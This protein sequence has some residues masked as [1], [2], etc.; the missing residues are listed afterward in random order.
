MLQMAYVQLDGHERKRACREKD[1]HVIA[2]WT[3]GFLHSGLTDATP[4]ERL[5][6]AKQC[7]RSCL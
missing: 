5:A 4:N 7:S 1:D 6:C 2:W 3:C